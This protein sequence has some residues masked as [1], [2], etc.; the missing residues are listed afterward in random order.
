MHGNVVQF[1]PASRPSGLG[2]S[3]SVPSLHKVLGGWECLSHSQDLVVVGKHFTFVAYC[4]LVENPHLTTNMY[5]SAPLPTSTKFLGKPIIGQA[6][7][8]TCFDQYFQELS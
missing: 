7:A 8:W 1:G 4:G 2:K 3:T 5:I 6:D